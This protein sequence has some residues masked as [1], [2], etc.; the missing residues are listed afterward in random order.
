MNPRVKSVTPADGHK[1]AIALTF[2]KLLDR[3]D[4]PRGRGFHALRHTFRTVADETRDFPAVD[5][6]M[7]HASLTDPGGGRHVFSEVLHRAVPLLGGFGAAGDSL[8]AWPNK[9]S[10]SMNRLTVA[11]PAR[12]RARSFGAELP[13]GRRGR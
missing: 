12:L 3:L 9:A 5:L 1:D 8:L 7:G 11:T 13:A 10:S 4:I 2:G 6:V